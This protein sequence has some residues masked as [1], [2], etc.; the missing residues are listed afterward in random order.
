MKLRPEN[1][2]TNKK[3]NYGKIIV[4]LTA[5]AYFFSGPGQTYFISGFIDVYVNELGWA[6]TTVSTLYSLATLLS[7]LLIYNIGYIADRI[8]T[9]KTMIIVGILLGVTC[10]WNSFNVNYITLVIGFFFSRFF[11][12]GSMKLLPS[13]VIPN[14]FVKKRA[15][16]FSLF[17]I[18]NVVASTFMPIINA[19][20]FT[21]TSWR[22]VW[23]LWGILVWVIFVPLT[24]F[25]LFDKP[26]DIGL[27][28]DNE[29]KKEESSK[30]FKF[31]KDEVYFSL[32]EA[33]K[34]FSF[35]GMLYCHMIL[36]LISTGLT[37]HLISILGSKNVTPGQ[38]ALILSLFSVV[39]FPVTLIAGRFMDKVKLNHIA[40]LISGLQLGS[41]SK[42]PAEPIRQNNV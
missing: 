21:V 18:G 22:N 39:S 23:R 1:L 34:T 9:K 16:A 15:K 42:K 40:A 32:K 31:S 35:W 20:L 38:S 11:G 2:Y 5:L 37:F 24:Y 33:M 14:W 36:P 8:G 29:K 30:D 10:F 26:E 3:I 12:Q 19:S 28:P 6:R 41:F 13:L 27:L 7:G 17:A 25:Y 4:F